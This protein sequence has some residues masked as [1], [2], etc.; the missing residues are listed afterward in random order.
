M[1]LLLNSPVGP[2]LVAYDAEGVRSLDFWRQGEHPPADTRDAPPPGDTVGRQLVREFAEYFA[3]ERRG[4]SV[5]LRPQGTEFQRRV[6]QS[7]REIPWGE[8]RSYREVAEAVGSPAAVRAV[9]QA[10]RR[11][12]LPILIPC[13]RVVPAGGGIGGYAGQEAG[14]GP[15]VKEWLLRLEGGMTND[16]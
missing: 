13:H 14:A 8:T 3:G 16:E 1:R 9:G 11:N 10:N 7:L 2:L 6:W 5:S 12:P 15:A 4:F